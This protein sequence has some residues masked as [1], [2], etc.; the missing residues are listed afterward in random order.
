MTW[1]EKARPIIKRVLQ[2][3]KGKTEQQ[4]RKALVRAYPFGPRENHPYFAWL[5]E[6]KVQRGLKKPKPGP[7]GYGHD[8]DQLTLF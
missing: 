4:I 5:D 7:G 3:T 2:E 6:I 1:R 8:E